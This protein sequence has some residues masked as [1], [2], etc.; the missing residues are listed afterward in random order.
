M[1]YHAYDWDQLIILYNVGPEVLGK[2][3][4]GIEI[5]LFMDILESTLI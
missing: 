2:F 5:G 1:T 4:V 3:I